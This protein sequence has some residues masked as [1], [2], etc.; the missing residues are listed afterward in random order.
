GCSAYRVQ[1]PTHPGVTD[2]RD[3]VWSYVWGVIPGQ[4]EVDCQGQAIAEVTMTSN[5]GFDLLAVV[6]L[7]LVAPKTVEWK[8]AGAT[9]SGG[10]IGGG[11]I[12]SR[13]IESGTVESTPVDDTTIDELSFE[14]TGEKQID[15]MDFEDEASEDDDQD[16]DVDG[17]GR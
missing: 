6:T 10:T 13:A 14:D 3:T 9:P 1:A 11:A 16:D 12:G 17:G 4:P 5:L 2:H 7:G 15:R 8:C